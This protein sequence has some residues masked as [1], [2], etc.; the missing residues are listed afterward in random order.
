M[1][2]AGPLLHD[3]AALVGETNVL[4][5]EGLEAYER[6]WRK[7][8]HGRALAVVRPGSTAEAAAVVRRCAQAR[9]AG[10]PVSLVPQGGNTGLVGGGVPD[11]SG[12][13]VVL[14][15]ARLRTIRRLDV[16]NLTI[17]VEAGCVLRD[18]QA[19]ADEAALL[20]PL[21]LAAEGSCTL[22]GNLATNA[23]GTQV[24]RYGNARELCLGLEVVTPAGDVWQRLDGLRKDNTGYDLRDLFVGSEGTLGL[25]TAAT[26]RLYPR[27][28]ARFTGWAACASLRDAVALLGR[29]RKAFD[30]ELIGFEAMNAASLA[31]VARHF[32]DLP[33]PLSNAN[34]SPAAPWAVLIE[35]ASPRDEAALQA[36]A[37]DVLAGALADGEVVD[38][39]AAR[40]VSQA[41]GLWHLRECIPL[42]Q[43]AEG[44][45]IKHDV[46]V[47]VSALAGFVDEADA[48]LDA[49][50]PGVR[51][52]TFGHL[53]DGNLH[54]NL[55]APEGAD[56]AVFLAR[57]EAA[58]NE[59]VYDIAGRVGGTFSAEHGIGRLRPGE[60]A[61][62][63]GPVGLALM[64]AIKQ[65]L[66]PLGLFNPGVV[67][68]SVDAASTDEPG[69]GAMGH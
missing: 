52:I 60:L 61:R 30:A 12:W 18:V 15:L 42:A 32:P 35:L 24:L 57:H 25:V 17:T 13:Q 58:A 29:V 54:Y 3:L 10:L 14:S 69:D 66:D 44:L 20:F 31:L 50:L 43:S 5:G 2:D 56:A 64:Q 22:G 16:D 55:Q 39:L 6:D 36:Q 67:L 45:N 41:R 19:A 23:G 28:R 48:R 27:P 40:S 11:G 38:A 1:T 53:G 26:M 65:A 21:S 62:R 49:L 37:E 4:R 34:R 68:P 8:W 33:H 51:H 7:R 47:P 59:V 63:R 46:A 9:Q